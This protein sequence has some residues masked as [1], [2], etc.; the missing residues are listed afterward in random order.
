MEQEISSAKVKPD[1]S[2]KNFDLKVSFKEIQSIDQKISSA[3]VKPDRA[4]QNFD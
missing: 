2:I 1:M 3:K 4:T